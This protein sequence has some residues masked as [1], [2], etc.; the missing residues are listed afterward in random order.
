MQCFAAY[1]KEDWMVLGEIQKAF[2]VQERLCRPCFG[3]LILSKSSFANCIIC[4]GK[5]SEVAVCALG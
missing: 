2:P 1:V 5:P 3:I 4:S